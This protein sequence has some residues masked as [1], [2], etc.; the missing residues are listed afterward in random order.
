M[1]SKMQN[2]TPENRFWK[3]LG[4]SD[5]NDLS[6]HRIYLQSFSKINIAPLT[7][8]VI[9]GGFQISN[10]DNASVWLVIVDTL[11][12]FRLAPLN[13]K[14]LERGI[15]L[16]ILKPVGA[17]IEYAL[18]D[19]HA[20]CWACFEKRSQL[21]DGPAAYLNHK[22]SLPYPVTEPQSFTSSSLMLAFTWIMTELEKMLKASTSIQYSGFLRSLNLASMQMESHIITRLSHCSV[23]NDHNIKTN[24]FPKKPD[25]SIHQRMI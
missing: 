24:Y 6:G 20:S 14:A 2:Y 21:I 23:C 25:I 9:Q 18:F 11:S 4:H 12:D 8:L 5:L 7:E 10:T 19:G 3:Q 16:L 22:L 15:K 17:E 1:T 13:K